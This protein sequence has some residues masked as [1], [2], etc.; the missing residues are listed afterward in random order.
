ME[1]H[2]R[3]IGIVGFIKVKVLGWSMIWYTHFYIHWDI[4]PGRKW[5]D[6][7]NISVGDKELERA[8]VGD[9]IMV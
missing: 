6:D 5:F 8:I 7:G 4:L 9:C 2:Y 1:D 3:W